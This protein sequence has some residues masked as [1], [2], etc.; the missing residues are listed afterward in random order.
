MTG[1]LDVHVGRMDAFFTLVYTNGRH[2]IP[3]RA[4]GL[5]YYSSSQIQKALKAHLRRA[6][7][8]S[9]QSEPSIVLLLDLDVRLGARPRETRTDL[10]FILQQ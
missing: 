8:V 10:Q 5:T 6:G 7:V 1:A 4:T 3:H 9:A 2:A